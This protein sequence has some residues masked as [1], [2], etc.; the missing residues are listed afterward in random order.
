MILNVN[1]VMFIVFNVIKNLQ[2]VQNA[3]EYNLI[4]PI[5]QK[6]TLHFY[7]FITIHKVHVRI[8]ALIK[9]IHHI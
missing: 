6:L 8:Y 1:I 9:L 4:I 7:L 3:K 5:Q 2:T